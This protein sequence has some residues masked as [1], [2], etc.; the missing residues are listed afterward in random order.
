MLTPIV[1]GDRLLA[2]CVLALFG[3][4][5]WQEVLLI[6]VVV[7]ILFG[8]RKIPELARNLGKGLRQFKRE[9]GGVK[10]EFEEAVE[11]AEEEEP[12]ASP[13][14]KRRREKRQPAADAA[15]R[16]ADETPP[17]EQAAA[18]APSEET[19]ADGKA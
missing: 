18:E 3:G 7:L 15:D 14:P 12:Y 2:A 8:G 4:L 1:L 16:P 5:G 10:R 11:T 19:P 6:V 17:D 9:M 13:E